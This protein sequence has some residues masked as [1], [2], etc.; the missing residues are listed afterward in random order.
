[1]SSFFKHIPTKSE[2]A[3]VF[4]YEHVKILISFIDPC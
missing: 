4:V 2:S 3:V 1:M